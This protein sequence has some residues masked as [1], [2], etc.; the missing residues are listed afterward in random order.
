MPADRFAPYPLPPHIS[1]SEYRK[2]KIRMIDGWMRKKICYFFP[3]RM[4]NQLWKN[5]DEKELIEV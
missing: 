4:Q 2:V 3:I 1:H 5:E